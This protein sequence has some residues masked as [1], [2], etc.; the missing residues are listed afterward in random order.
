MA[1]SV[2]ALDQSLIRCTPFSPRAAEEVILV[3]LDAA[4]AVI[5]VREP[6]AIVANVILR[7]LSAVALIGQNRIHRKSN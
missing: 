2:Y 1:L 5:A 7:E 6:T 4:V 3:M